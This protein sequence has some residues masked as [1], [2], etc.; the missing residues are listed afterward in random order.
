MYHYL[1]L[2]TFEDSMQYVGARS[3]TIK[4]ELD[5]M[6]LGSGAKLPPRTR[7]TC[8]KQILKEFDTRQKLIEAEIKY[9]REHN[10]IKSKKYYNLVEST[11]D[12]HGEKTNGTHYLKGET[13]E[14]SLAIQ[15]ANVKRFQYTGNNRTPAQLA[16]D[17]RLKET[18]KGIK[19]PS[20]GHKS[21]SNCSFV[22]W[23]YITPSGEY[24]EIYDK[25]KRDLAKTLGFTER[26]LIHRFHKTNM[27]KKGNRGIAKG[28]VF[29]NLPKNTESG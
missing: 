11:Y 5:A 23:Y 12:R 25:T 16:H 18:T 9:I 7:H 27:H 17:Q 13:K 15:K 29:G 8:T 3:T 2:I 22:P 4:P 24:F 26:Q 6:Y 20:K 19:N 1:Y 10:C 21:V 28:W 14:T